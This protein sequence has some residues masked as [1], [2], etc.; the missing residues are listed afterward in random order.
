M[1]LSANAFD[2]RRGNGRGNGAFDPGATKK[3]V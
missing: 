3:I 2:Q 1:F